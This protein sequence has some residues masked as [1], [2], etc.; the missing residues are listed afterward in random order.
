MPTSVYWYCA[1]LA[2]VEIWM[3]WVAWKYTVMPG[4]PATAPFMRSTM[5]STRSA[6]S[7]RGFRLIT[8]RPALGVAFSV[9]TPITETTPATLGSLRIAA[10][11]CCWRRCI[12]AKETSVPASVTAVIRPVSCNGRKPLGIAMYSATVAAMVISITIS[13]ANWRRSTHSSVV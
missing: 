1:R 10:S 9:L 7:S 4:I 11:T 3:S 8:S 6:R 12:S 2:R 13:V 5:A